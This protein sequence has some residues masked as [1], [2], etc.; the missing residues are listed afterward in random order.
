MATTSDLIIK[1]LAKLFQ[2]GQITS[3]QLAEILKAFK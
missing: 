3:Q 1:E 2:E